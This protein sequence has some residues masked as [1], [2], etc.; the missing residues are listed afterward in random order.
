MINFLCNYFSKDKSF[1]KKK[2][3]ACLLDNNHLKS[4]PTL[5]LP[6]PKKKKKRERKKKKASMFLIL[7]NNKNATTIR[8]Q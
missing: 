4:P 6:S 7:C 1:S 5:D 2:D 3:E 8:Y